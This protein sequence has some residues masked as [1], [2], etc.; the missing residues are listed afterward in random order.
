MIY[1]DHNA[2]SPLRD[3]SRD[4]VLRAL[5]AGG[6]ASSVHGAGRK[7]RGLV[8]HARDALSALV[9]ARAGEIIFTS[10][11]TE[12][13]ALALRGIIAGALEAENR[14][15]RLF[16]SAVEHDSIGALTKSLSNTVPGVKLQTIAVT[17]DGVVDLPAFRLQ[18]MQGK[19]R[20]LVC[21]MAANNET[22]VVQPIADIVKLVRLEGEDSLVHVD[23][24]QALGRM[25]VAFALW[26]ADSMSISSH[27]I[28]G[29]QG[30]GALVIKDNAPLAPLFTGFQEKTRRAGTENV[31]AIAGLGAAAKEALENL[32]AEVTRLNALRTRFEDGLHQI[33]PDAVIFGEV[34]PRLC[35]TIA[36]AIPGLSAESTLIAL[37]L[38]G[39]ALSSGAACSSGKVRASHVLSAM[40][41]DEA[42]RHGALRLSMG[43]NTNEQNID[44]A[45]AA[46][47]T[48]LRRAAAKAA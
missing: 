31:A 14:I 15:T 34:A 3:S 36:F 23:A 25:D 40:N 39:I 18:L 44:A 13:N 37:D 1:L 47:Q 20:A 4:A 32:G 6:N 38:D 43:W 17:K 16:V 22:G 19:G 5:D 33:S 45:L 42:L 12:A 35:N 9:G 10:G 41:V 46:L 2:S 7:A 29:P 21:V 28:G 8:E 24:V 30:A 11:G 27:K 26:G 48:H